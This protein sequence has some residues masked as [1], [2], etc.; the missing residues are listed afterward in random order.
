MGAVVE[1]CV[2]HVPSAEILAIESFIT[3]HVEGA[4]RT[5]V[6]TVFLAH[7]LHWSRSLC[8]AHTPSS[9]ATERREFDWL[10][11]VVVIVVL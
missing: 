2:E 10:L 9:L 4:V 1:Q 6:R 7:L 8:P 5:Y 3:A 11:T